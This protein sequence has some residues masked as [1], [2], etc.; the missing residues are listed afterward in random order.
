MAKAVTRQCNVSKSNKHSNLFSSA[1]QIGSKVHQLDSFDSPCTVS[2]PEPV[3][4]R[5]LITKTNCN[6]KNSCIINCDVT[7]SNKT[8]KSSIPPSVTEVPRTPGR[9]AFSEE[10]PTKRIRVSDEDQLAAGPSHGYAMIPIDVPS[11]PERV[12]SWARFDDEPAG[13]KGVAPNIPEIAMPLYRTL[14]NA[15]SK[16][17]KAEIV[18]EY[19]IKYHDVK[20]TPKTLLVD[21]Q[22]PFGRDDAD[23]MSSW[24]SI[25]ATAEHSFNGILCE[26]AR[27]IMTSHDVVINEAR[28][29]LARCLTSDAQ[30]LEATRA[31][32]SVNEK[33]RRKERASREDKL[34]KDKLANRERA[35]KRRGLPNP[36]SAVVR[37][38][39]KSF[40]PRPAP[41]Q[42]K[43]PRQNPNQQQANQ[44]P[45]PR[46]ANSNPSGQRRTQGRDQDERTPRPRGQARQSGPNNQNQVRSQVRNTPD[47][48]PDQTSQIERFMKEIKKLMRK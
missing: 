14:R 44:R 8:N 19:A 39:D 33:V 31:I 29:T 21:V 26:K 3:T 10:N 6:N 37:P 11:R 38:S 36:V 20:I 34:I 23:L 28:A 22:P 43:G 42:G 24:Y 46:D 41:K 25:V 16:K 40:R 4:Q 15:E 5:N 9:E 13:P 7:I 1:F 30:I 27:S 47:L 18:L 35:N 45:S 17:A 32:G 2:K 48:R 12:P